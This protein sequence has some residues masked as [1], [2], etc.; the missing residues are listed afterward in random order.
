MRRWLALALALS[1]VAGFVQIGLLARGSSLFVVQRV[2]IQG[3]LPSIPLEDSELISIVNVQLG[4]T[5]IFSLDL[6]PIR[7]KIAGNPW[8]K[9]AWI[10]KEFSGT[11]RISVE[12]RVP[13]AQLIGQGHQLL[14]VDQQG[15]TFDGGA[16][17]FGGMLP[18]LSGWL[19][20]DSY[21]LK[22]A[23]QF[24]A[25][26]EKRKLKEGIVF[27]ALDRDEAKGLRGTLHLK[28]AADRVARPVVELGPT[29]ED[30]VKISSDRLQKFFSEVRKRQ[31]A[32]KRIWLGDGNKIVVKVS[33]SS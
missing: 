5:P 25:G 19:A 14:Y 32:P 1:L 6:E 8:V 17:T 3:L 11:L 26:W 33:D 31:L 7:L 22:E 2:S 18:T 30:A 27:T 13:V 10:G 15:V 20:D 29:F 12:P 16:K 23:V 4:K 24:L 28:L 9:S 21:G